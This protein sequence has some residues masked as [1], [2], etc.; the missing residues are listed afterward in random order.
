MHKA[1]LLICISH[2][3]SIPCSYSPSSNPAYKHKY[4]KKNTVSSK[5]E[6]SKANIEYRWNICLSCSC[7]HKNVLFLS[8]CLLFIPL[9]RLLRWLPV[10]PETL[11]SG[12]H[13]NVFIFRFPIQQPT[14]MRVSSKPVLENLHSHEAVNKFYRRSKIFWLVSGIEPGTLCF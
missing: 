11:H 8:L 4:I 14:P 5:R 7:F 6:W 3:S 12:H 2:N 13:E 1:A 10:A 9:Q